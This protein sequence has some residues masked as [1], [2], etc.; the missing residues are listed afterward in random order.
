MNMLLKGHIS[1]PHEE[2]KKNPQRLDTSQKFFKTWQE[3]PEAQEEERYSCCKEQSEKMLRA[4]VA[5]SF[6]ILVS[7]T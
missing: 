1:L 7:V 4:I 5:K 2:E 6:G 3:I